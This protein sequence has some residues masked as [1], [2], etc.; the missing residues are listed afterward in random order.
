MT[1]NIPQA[2]LGPREAQFLIA[3]ASG[4]NGVFSIDDAHSYWSDPARARQAVARLEKKGWLKRIERGKYLVVPL[5]AGPKRTWMED[6]LVIAMSLRSDGVVGY[7]SA[8]NYWS[9]SEQISRTVFVQSVRRR[10]VAE[11]IVLGVRYRFITVTSAKFFGVSVVS[12]GGSPVRITDREKTLIDCLDRPDL[13]GGVRQLAVII[14]KKAPQLDWDKFDSYL[15]GFPSSAAARRAGYIVEATGAELP[16][17]KERIAAWRGLV[18][19]GY[20]NLEPG[21]WTGGKLNR[22]WG[23]RDNAG[24]A[25]PNHLCPLDKWQV[26]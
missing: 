1:Q 3:V 14:G 5:E 26:T 23:I 19:S 17:Q 12:I 10:N 22:R 6:S 4:S 15:A 18:K 20:L 9:M 13:A 21:S 24:L 8:L 16:A 7:W 25:E 11:K 2:G